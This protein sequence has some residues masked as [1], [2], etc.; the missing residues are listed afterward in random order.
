M[1]HEPPSAKTTGSHS[2]GVKPR[3]ATGSEAKLLGHEL[4]GQT[5]GP[6]FWVR[7]TS[8]LRGLPIDLQAGGVVFVERAFASQILASLF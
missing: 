5:S 1:K 8:E 4:R 7:S 2:H 3:E 6:N